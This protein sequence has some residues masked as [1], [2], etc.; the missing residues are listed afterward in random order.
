[1]STAGITVFTKLPVANDSAGALLSKRIELVDGQIVSD[2]APCRMAVGDAE[3][4]PAA[5]AADLARILVMMDSN[6]ALALGTIKGHAE[7]RIVTARTLAKMQEHATAKGL[8]IIARSRAYIDYQAGPAWM[9]CDFDRKG[10]PSTVAA[11][12]ADRGGMWPALLSNAP[13]LAQAARVTRAS[14]ACGH[15][16]PGPA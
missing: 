1:M 16:A 7:A 3:V 10:M 6:N 14:A 2:G 4:V 13:G 8:P 11:A 9:L 5:S 15:P 12:I